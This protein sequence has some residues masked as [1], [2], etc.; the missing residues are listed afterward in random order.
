MLTPFDPHSPQQEKSGCGSPHW[1]QILSQLC[2]VCCY[3]VGRQAA[4][5]LEACRAGS[6]PVS[7]G[8]GEQSPSDIW[9][10]LTEGILSQGSQGVG[11]LMGVGSKETGGAAG[12][13]EVKLEK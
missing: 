6:A 3:S 7:V 11:M 8:Q 10:S 1:S 12:R 4:P 2:N 9:D 5:P 13:E